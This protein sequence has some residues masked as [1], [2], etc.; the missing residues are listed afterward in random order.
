MRLGLLFL[1]QSYVCGSDSVIALTLHSGFYFGG[2]GLTA[3]P[4]ARCPKPEA[5]AS[6]VR[7]HNNTQVMVV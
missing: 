4:E 6:S 2:Q 7:I 1:P 5:G 3:L